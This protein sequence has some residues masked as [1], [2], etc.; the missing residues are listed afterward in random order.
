MRACPLHWPDVDRKDFSRITRQLAET[1]RTSA[2]ESTAS[3][4][5]Q[6]VL[7]QIAAIG[8]GDLDAAIANAHPDVQ[9]QIFAPPEFMW[10]RHAVGAEALR[11][12]I[13]HNFASVIE[14]VPEVTSVTAQ[15]E[16]VV[17]LGRERG[18]IRES[19]AAYDVE[20]VQRFQFRDGRLA[21]VKIIAAR[22]S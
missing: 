17:L 22:A 19:G 15:G 4:N 9:F 20:F 5:V 1:A 10:I 2:L 11:A 3:T 6:A 21:S 7:Q 8:R 16:T 12:A 14:Q 13:A 18:R